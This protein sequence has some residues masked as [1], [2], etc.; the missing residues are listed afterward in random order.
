[1]PLLKTPILLFHKIDDAFEWGITTQ[2]IKQF[3]REISFLFENGYRVVT[4]E[5]TEEPDNQNKKVIL[6][7]DDGYESIYLNAFPILQKYDMF[8]YVFIPTAYVGK[9]NLWDANLGN[10]KFRHLSW[11]QIKEMS[12]HGFLFGSHSVNHPDLTKLSDKYLQY[13]LKV[14]KDQ[15]EQKLG[16][17]VDFLSYPFGKTNPKVCAMAKE[18]GYKKGFTICKTASQPND[19][20]IARKPLYLIDSLLSF[21]I[22][23]EQNNGFIWLEDFKS[24][25]INSFANGTIIV[26]PLPKYD[27]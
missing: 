20:A 17:E 21:K 24:K 25:I 26:K 5:Q 9:L 8:G 13:E 18:V 2:K 6:T 23:L 19:F 27:V 7:F 15:L 16:R 4:L 11:E 1:M 12:K 3:E 14:S 22:K 10:K